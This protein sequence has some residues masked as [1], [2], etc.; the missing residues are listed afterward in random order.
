MPSA[1][2]AAYRHAGYR[3]EYLPGLRRQRPLPRQ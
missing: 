3:R 2:S 1:H